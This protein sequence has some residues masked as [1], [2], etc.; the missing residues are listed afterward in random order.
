MAQ[1]WL[2]FWNARTQRR[3]AEGARQPPRNGAT[4]WVP[5]GEGKVAVGDAEPHVLDVWHER[6]GDAIFRGE[7]LDDDDVGRRAL[8]YSDGSIRRFKRT[9]DGRVSG[10]AFQGLASIRELASG[11]EVT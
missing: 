8:R 3:H 9:E 5:Y 7:V 11:H 1:N 4:I 2:S 10:D 6:P